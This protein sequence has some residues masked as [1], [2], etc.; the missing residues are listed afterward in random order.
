[1]HQ[2]EQQ[3]REEM[4]LR[5]ARSGIDGFADEKSSDGRALHPHFDTV[6]PLI[7]DLFKANPQREL[8]EAYDA[9]CWAHPE[10]RKQMLAAEQHRARSQQDVARA[11]NAV[12][13]NTRGLTTPVARPNGA[14][15]P[16]KGTMRDAIESAADEIPGINPTRS[17]TWHLPPLRSLSAREPSRTTTSS[18]RTTSRTRTPS[19]RFCVKAIASAS[20]KAV[21]PSPAR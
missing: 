7:I 17:P 16:S 10:V 2:T 21:A 13:G 19:P 4:G 1:M 12:R 11:R 6:L 20:S 9:A 15:G 3:A 18:S 8:A 5:S 14:D